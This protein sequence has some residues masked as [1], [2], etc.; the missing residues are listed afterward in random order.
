M[1][2]LF[3]KDEREVKKNTFRTH[4]ISELSVLVVVLRITNLVLILVLVMNEGAKS[5]R[6]D[7]I[8]FLDG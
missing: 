2:L 4:P 3:A 1:V 7:D 8:D 5:C 6:D